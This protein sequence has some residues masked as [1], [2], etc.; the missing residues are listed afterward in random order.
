MSSSRLRGKTLRHLQDKPIID[1][2]YEN[3]EKVELVSNIVIATS[4]DASDDAL[5]SHCV[6]KNIPVYRGSLHNVASRFLDISREFNEEAFL[7]I[8]GDSPL[9]DPRLVDQ[10]IS[11]FNSGSADMVTNTL[12]RSYPKGQSVE[13]I[14]S[15]IFQ[16]TYDKFSSPAHFEH[17]TSYF[18][19]NFESFNIQNISSG[20][21]FG[22]IN[23]SVDTLEDL[24]RLNLVLDAVSDD[25]RGWLEYA[26]TYVEKFADA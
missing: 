19:E 21:D 1:H 16:G 8:N 23:L 13:I 4:E 10:M 17:V 6:E 12:E 9:I 22:N 3:I 14:N 15:D 25:D 7:R 20:G 2:V 26:S 18:Y 5:S 11:V 24:E